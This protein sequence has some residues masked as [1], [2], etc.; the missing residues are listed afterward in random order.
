MLRLDQVP[1]VAAD[2][3]LTDVLDELGDNDVKRALVLD[4]GR[5]VGL[6]SITD[7]AR[8]LEIGGRRPAV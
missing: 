1:V 5:L 7:V 4:D 3:R 8:A 6:L 2:D